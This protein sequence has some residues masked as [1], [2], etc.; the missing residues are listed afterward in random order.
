MVGMVVVV[1]YGE[2]AGVCVWGGASAHES[3]RT[4]GPGERKKR[5]NFASQF[6]NL[7]WYLRK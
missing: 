1:V 5:K 2:K 3:Y 4:H 7:L 6:G